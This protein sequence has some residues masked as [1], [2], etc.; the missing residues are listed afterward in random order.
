MDSSS[1]PNGEFSCGIYPFVIPNQTQ[2]NNIDSSNDPSILN[3]SPSSKQID[4]YPSAEAIENRFLSQEQSMMRI[5]LKNEY[6]ASNSKKDIQ[7]DFSLGEDLYADISSMVYG[8]N[9]SPTWYE[10][11]KLMLDSIELVVT[12]PSW[13][14]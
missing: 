11:K 1:Y 6:H 4:T 10:N 3:I 14:F 7:Y 12:D 13:N 8:N 5:Q 2:D 9:I